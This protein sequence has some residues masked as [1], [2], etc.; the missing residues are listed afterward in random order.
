MGRN[1]LS[2]VCNLDAWDHYFWDVT[3]NTAYMIEAYPFR[4]HLLTD[5]D[6]R[7]AA[8]PIQMLLQTL[9]YVV[10]YAEDADA[11]FNMHRD[12]R[13]D[14]WILTL[15]KARNASL[16]A[17]KGDRNKYI[18]SVDRLCFDTTSE[19]FAHREVIYLI[20]TMFY[21]INDI[22][23]RDKWH[24]PYRAEKLFYEVWASLGPYIETKH[25]QLI[26]GAEK[27]ATKK[28]AKIIEWLNQRGMY[29]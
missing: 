13:V 24:L 4:S 16:E 1:V 12:V 6:I 11:D 25:A 21:V 3:M 14:N 26:N 7:E 8:Y 28:A 17:G 5:K 15:E 9:R 22:L 27:S 20:Y 10:A 29:Q 19:F 23:T 18:R 2:D